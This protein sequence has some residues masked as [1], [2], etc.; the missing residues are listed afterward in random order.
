MRKIILTIIL[1]VIGTVQAKSKQPPAPPPIEPPTILVHNINTDQTV[2]SDNADIVRP[3]ASITKLMTAMVALDHYRLSDRIST[4]RKTTETVESLMTRLLVRSD[5]GASEILAQNYPGGRTKFLEAMN[6]KTKLLG[7]NNTQFNDPSGL[8]ATNTTTAKDLVKLVSAAGTY[9]FISA[10]S[11]QP[12]IQQTTPGKKRPHTVVM[13][14]T[15]RNILFEF[16][17]I[18]VSKTGFTSRAG[19]CLAML[20]DKQG[21]RYAIII[22]GEPSKQAREQVARNLL[23]LNIVQ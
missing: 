15:N 19:R 21:Q 4:G 9:E 12:E 17:N 8:I 14:N 3:M 18:L 2:V 7:L 1:A 5:N 23:T 6:V 20:V 13:P 16:N 11:R 22:L 10:V